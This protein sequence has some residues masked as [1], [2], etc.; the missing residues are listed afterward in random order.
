MKILRSELDKAMRRQFARSVF[1]PFLNRVIT[2]DLV[3]PGSNSR[4]EMQQLNRDV[5][6]GA[7]R[8]RN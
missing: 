1:S 6:I 2:I 3:A 8:G 7:M 4:S 5:S